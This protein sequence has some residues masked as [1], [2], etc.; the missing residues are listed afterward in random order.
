VW[1]CYLKR[2]FKG[3]K[4]KNLI[5]II[6]IILGIFISSIKNN[7][8]YSTLGFIF[9]PIQ[10]VTCSASGIFNNLFSSKELENYKNKI[11]EQEEE[12]QKLRLLTIDYY[13]IKKENVRY[14]K[15]YELK[16]QDESLKFAS[17]AVIGRS[18]DEES[19]GFTLD[20]GSLV[21]ISEN[22]PVITSKGLIGWVSSVGAI[23]CNVKTL[24]SPEARIGS[25][26][27]E[28]G[29]SG[30]ITG[31]S[32]LTLQNLTR[33]MYLPPKS[34]LKTDDIVVTSGLG[35]SYPRDLPI[36]KVIKIKNDESTGSP[37]AEIEPFEDIENVR[38]VFVIIDF[39]GKGDLGAG[40][41]ERK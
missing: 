17:A 4:I 2:F 6:L 3:N 25:V 33:L 5:Y 40:S 29:D 12:I 23:S 11:K 1:C 37:C 26:C 34:E 36:G 10:K 8:F 32:K 14:E 41:L 31:T 13:N 9:A 21:G 7:F 15:Y 35:G 24:F 16:K 39:W 18:P 22:D 28:S 27:K 20:Q 19:C 30:V 38:D